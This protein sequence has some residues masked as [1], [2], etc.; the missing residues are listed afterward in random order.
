M[1]WSTIG[2]FALT[3]IPY[4]QSLMG[5]FVAILT[6]VTSVLS[7]DVVLFGRTL[8]LRRHSAFCELT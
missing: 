7:A 4:S 3:L 2:L 1:F 8:S 5:A 6:T